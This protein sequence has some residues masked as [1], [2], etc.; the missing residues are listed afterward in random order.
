MPSAT[1]TQLQHLTELQ[2]EDH[3]V[4]IRIDEKLGGY[5]QESRQNHSTIV[6][7][8]ADH[9]TRIGVLERKDEVAKG[10]LIAKA[11]GK[12]DL[13]EKIILI[14]TVITAFATWALTGFKGIR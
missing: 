14:A 9:E 6:K 10:I 5:I 2:R 12:K 1:E 11:A 7:T 13:A 4:T 3:D 8:L